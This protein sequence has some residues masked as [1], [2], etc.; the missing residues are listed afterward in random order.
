MNADFAEVSW[1]ARDGHAADPCAL[2]LH[3]EQCRRACGP[4]HAW[5]SL[6]EA[7][8]TAL[9]PRFVTTVAAHAALVALA[10]GIAWLA[11]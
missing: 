2:A 6:A 11:G 9:R 1:P 8:H 10:L 7:A 3:R 5:R 4:W